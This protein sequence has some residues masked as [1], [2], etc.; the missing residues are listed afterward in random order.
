MRMRFVE[1]DAL[2]EII[3]DLWVD[4][5]HDVQ[6]LRQISIDRQDVFMYTRDKV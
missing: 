2:R 1:N 5:L 4:L 6:F 3:T